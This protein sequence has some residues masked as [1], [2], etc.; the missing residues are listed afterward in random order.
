MQ[1]SKL[2][3]NRIA[4][5]YSVKVRGHKSRKNKDGETAATLGPIILT[6]FPEAEI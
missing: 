1:V 6:Y 2:A 4:L 5:Y 3:I